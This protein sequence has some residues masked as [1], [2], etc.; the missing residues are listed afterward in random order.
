[1]SANPMLEPY[2]TAAFVWGDRCRAKQFEGELGNVAR[3]AE[4]V[5]PAGDADRELIVKLASAVSRVLDEV[6]LQANIT[7]AKS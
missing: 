6:D 5:L 3:A 4:A 2:P 1:M 7:G